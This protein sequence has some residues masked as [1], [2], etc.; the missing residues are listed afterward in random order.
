MSGAT[1]I[2]GA[3][4]LLEKGLGNSILDLSFDVEDPRILIKMRDG[5]RVYIQYNDHDQYSYSILFTDGKLDRSRFDNY[6][7]RWAVS[8]RPHHFHP[9]MS[10]QAFESIMTG[11]P[12]NDMPILCDLIKKGKLFSDTFSV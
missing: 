9:R 11:K 2:Q 4:E 1:Q 12:K 5:I 8:T 7:N 3:K 6:D 10:K